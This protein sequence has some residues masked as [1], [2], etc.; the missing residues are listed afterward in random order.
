MWASGSGQ[1][2][3]PLGGLEPP[4]ASQP[5]PNLGRWLVG[6]GAGWGGVLAMSEKAARPLFPWSSSE[7]PVGWDRVGVRFPEEH[8]PRQPGP[9]KKC[10]L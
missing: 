6:G 7:R 4:L 8:P 1:L 10:G 2:E 5:G 9:W 3:S